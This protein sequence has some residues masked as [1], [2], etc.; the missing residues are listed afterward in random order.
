MFMDELNLYSTNELEDISSALWVI[1]DSPLF[2]THNLANN[3]DI[4]EE[5]ANLCAACRDV[6]GRIES[7]A[8]ETGVT[9]YKPL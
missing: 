7:A 5:L 2:V 1:A 6:V 9:L 4:G 3:T 8:K